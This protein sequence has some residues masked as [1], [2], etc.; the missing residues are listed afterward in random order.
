MEGVVLEVC[1][2]G[3]IEELHRSGI[4]AL[5]VVA[6]VNLPRCVL[7]TELPGKVGLFHEVVNSEKDIDRIPS[8]KIPD[9][10]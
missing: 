2:E 6:A 9:H 7:T 5:V 3:P 1:T 4:E 10:Q 8:R